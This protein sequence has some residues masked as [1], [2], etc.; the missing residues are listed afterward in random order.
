MFRN[1]FQWATV[2]A[3]EERR[4]LATIVF[5]RRDQDVSLES[6]AD[7]HVREVLWLSVSRTATKLV[8]LL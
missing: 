1:R 2:P 4:R 5:P 7:G 3:R 6:V 8:G